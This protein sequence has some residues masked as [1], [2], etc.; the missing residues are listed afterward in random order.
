[1]YHGPYQK[2]LDHSY[3]HVY[4]CLLLC[5]MLV[6]ASPVLGFAM[7]GTLRGL[8]LSNAHEAFF[9]CNHLGGISRC[10]VRFTWCYAYHACL[11]HPLAFYA[12]LHTCSH[13]HAWVVFASVL[14]MLKHN[15]V[16]DIRS[17]TTFVPR[18]H[19]LLFAFLLVCLFA[20][21]L[22]CLPSSSLAYLVTC[23]ISCHMLCL[24]RLYACLLLYP[25]CI[26]Y[27]SLFLPLLVY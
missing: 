20:C 8:D 17:K 27:A 13:V 14:S 22:V 25:L 16:M 12:S 7:F 5:F 15:E 19:H 1:M 9:G 24:L 6:L 10:Q 3:L 23:H 2:G 4:A 26:I 11:C 21:F 18:R